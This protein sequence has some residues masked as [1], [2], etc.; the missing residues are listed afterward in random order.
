MKATQ[1]ALEL[2]PRRQ[3]YNHDCSYNLNSL[4]VHSYPKFGHTCGIT[5]SEHS[6]GQTLHKQDYKLDITAPES[7]QHVTFCS[8]SRAKSYTC[9][10]L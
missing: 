1:D 8:A 6:T 9:F 2:D 4:Q 7:H 3:S 5:F 10:G